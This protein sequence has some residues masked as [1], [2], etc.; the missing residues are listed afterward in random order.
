MS[1]VLD[2]IFTNGPMREV[3]D[4]SVVRVI[5][6]GR[7]LYLKD[8]P[9]PRFTSSTNNCSILDKVSAKRLRDLVIAQIAKDTALYMVC[10]REVEVVQRSIDDT[11]ASIYEK[12]LKMVE[13]VRIKDLIPEHLLEQAPNETC[14]RKMRQTLVS[15]F[16]DIVQP[17]YSDSF[18]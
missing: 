11:M 13:V 5:V 15:L 7:A 16:R 14:P 3:L 6:E 2:K 18:V 1:P 12:V 9:T 17:E 10:G 8:C 4:L